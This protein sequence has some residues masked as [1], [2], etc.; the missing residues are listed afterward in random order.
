MMIL[1]AVVNIYMLCKCKGLPQFL[2]LKLI[3]NQFGLND[4]THY[5]FCFL[6]DLVCFYSDL[7]CLFIKCIDN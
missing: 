6:F 5:M 7:Y 4:F 2:L 3:M 1:A